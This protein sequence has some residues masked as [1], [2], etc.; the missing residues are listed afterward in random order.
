MASLSL[1]PA[2]ARAG[3]EVKLDKMLTGV[4]HLCANQHSLKGSKTLRQSDLARICGVSMFSAVERGPISLRMPAMGPHKEVPCVPSVL[5][6]SPRPRRCRGSG[7]SPCPSCMLPGASIRS[8][9]SARLRS[10]LLLFQCRSSRGGW[11]AFGGLDAEV[12]CRPRKRAPCAGK[13]LRRERTRRF[14]L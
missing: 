4:Q 8:V 10:W 5:D 6:V 13:D 7:A 12:C 1:I 11:G 2:V 3:T 9:C 14:R